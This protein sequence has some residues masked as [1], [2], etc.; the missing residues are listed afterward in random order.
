[1]FS[2][3]TALFTLQSFSTIV[4][5]VQKCPKNELFSMLKP[6]HSAWNRLSLE[7]LLGQ[8]NLKSLAPSQPVW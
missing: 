4:D 5:N 2:F 8:W 3:S 1:M 7:D 6:Q